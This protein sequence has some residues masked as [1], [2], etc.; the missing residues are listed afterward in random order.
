M[1]ERL[2]EQIVSTEEGNDLEHA[3]VV[4]RCLVHDPEAAEDVR[5]AHDENGEP[6]QVMER[7]SATTVA[8]SF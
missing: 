7:P 6:L 8:S 3:V 4:L 2:C 1:D 5:S